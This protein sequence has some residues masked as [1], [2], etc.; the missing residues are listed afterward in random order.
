MV[1]WGKSSLFQDYTEAEFLIFAK[2]FSTKTL[3]EERKILAEFL[4]HVV[5]P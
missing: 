5:A 1:K 3:K 2:F 4:N